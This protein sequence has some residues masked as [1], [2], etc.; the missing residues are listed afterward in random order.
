MSAIQASPKTA[1]RVIAAAF[2]SGKGITI[3]RDVAER[4]FLPP[5]GRV[6]ATVA[7]PMGTSNQVPSTT[8]HHE[9]RRKLC[10]VPSHNHDK[11]VVQG[12]FLSD[13]AI[14]D[15]WKAHQC[16]HLK[17]D[18][19]E[20]VN[21][22]KSHMNTKIHLK[23]NTFCK[24]TMRRNLPIQSL[25]PSSKFDGPEIDYWSAHNDTHFSDYWREQRN[26]HF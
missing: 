24:P 19:G 21:Y 8:A 3:S 17:L 26:T 4:N 10:S 6:T 7:I 20:V 15:Y 2:K 14:I 18:H 23:S 1:N 9:V 13:G 25:V 11:I 22:W 5:F 16:D 12:M